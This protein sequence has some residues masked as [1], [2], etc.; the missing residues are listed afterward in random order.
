MRDLKIMTG[1]VYF[2]VAGV[3]TSF[4][5]GIYSAVQQHRELSKPQQSVFPTPA[6]G[7]KSAA[8]SQPQRNG[9]MPTPAQ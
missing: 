7:G 4:A 6:E 5:G 8:P 3:V 2:C 9:G 1:L